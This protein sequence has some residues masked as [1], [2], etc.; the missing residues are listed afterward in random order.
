MNLGQLLI[1]ASFALAVATTLLHFGALRGKK[2]AGASQ[3]FVLHAGALVAAVLLL[4]RHFAAH[5]FQFAYVAEH[6][7]RA[8][9]PIMAIAA[10]WAG[11]EGSILLW[12]AIVAVLGLAL[13]RQPGRLS[14]PALFFVSASQLFLVGILLIRSPFRLAPAVPADGFGLN[15]L[16]EDPWM[17]AHPPALFVGYAALVV[18]FALAAAALV[19]NEFKDWNRAV[20][21]WALFGTLGLGIGIVLGGIW[22]YKV[23]GWGGFWGW[24]PVE[25]AS[26]IPWLTT[27]AL[28]HGLL[29]Q[30]TT[31]SLART[32]L[33]LALLGWVL[34]VGGT[35][36]TRSG[37]LQDFSVHSFAD[38]GLNT[39][40]VSFLAG[41]FALGAVLMVWRW[42]SIP[43]A[44]T[45]IET[46]SREGA[47]WL[48]LLTVVML[49][50]LVT[51]GTTSPLL[52]SLTGRPASV[53]TSFYNMIA[54]PL[55]VV[56]ALLMALA[57]ALRWSRQNGLTWLTALAPGFVAGVL[58]GGVAFIFGMHDAGWI[59]IVTA[60]GFALGVN[61]QV[62][63]RLFRRGWMYGAGYLG[64]VGIAVMILGIVVSAT[65]GRS[66]QVTLR[67]GESQEALGYTLTFKGAERGPRGEQ[68]MRVDVAAKGWRHEARPMLLESPQTNGV[69]RTPDISGT[70][71]LYISPMD[72]RTV[73]GDDQL[74][75]LGK[76]EHVEIDGATYAFDG[77]R[78]ENHGTMLV[79]ADVTVRSHGVTWEVR[80]AI[81]MGR[82]GAVARDA[83]ISGVGAIGLRHVDVDQG[84]VALALPGPHIHAA[85]L[86]TI[87]VSTKPWINLV[88]V[89]ALLALI[90]TAIAGLRRA[91]EARPAPVRRVRGMTPAS[92]K[93]TV[94]GAQER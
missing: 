7:S 72:L 81:E 12:A 49:A 50:A 43:S 11:Q 37:V 56:L 16:L 82:D 90:G 31:G 13:M 53:Q 77:F 35:Y 92:A 36:M 22:A 57:P 4:I 70:R 41:T 34:V 54:L 89:G 23:L 71:D 68:V 85:A 9:T 66:A 79:T 86:A 78:M 15:P 83:E 52:T 30:R 65:L 18:P 63:A 8:L 61:A 48:G 75:W 39:P 20:W 87:E 47:L 10:S 67:E 6:S 28:V 32:N 69:V 93:L 80:P 58:A 60:T 46:L 27:V 64:H 62:A 84:R 26:L 29:I 91:G 21:P 24:D 55:G 40:L 2:T 42:K 5:D 38:S 44:K 17:V 3:T 25:N 51:V 73:G 88:W 76:G 74:T 45:T 1:Q 33:S 94:P 19:R 59:T 14:R